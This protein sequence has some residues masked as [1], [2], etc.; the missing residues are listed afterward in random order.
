ML[1]SKCNIHLRLAD[2]SEILWGFLFN[3]Y[4]MHGAFGVI[5]FPIRQV[6]VTIK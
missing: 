1:C 3:I 2:K 6:S 4:M 5:L